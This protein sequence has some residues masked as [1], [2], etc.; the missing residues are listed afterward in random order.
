MGKGHD[1]KPLVTVGIPLYNH[2]NYIR[3]C[4]ESVLDQSYKNIQVIVIDDGSSDSSFAVLQE[5]ATERCDERLEISSRE[6]RG[7]CNTLNEIAVAARGKYISMLGSDDYWMPNKIADQVEY[8][9]CRPEYVLVH[10]GSIKVDSEGR[11]IKKLDYSK[12]ENTGWLFEA[13]IYRRGGINTPS[14]LYRTS[15]YE[16]IGYYDPQ[17]TFEDADFWLRLTKDFDV[18]Y[19]DKDHTFYRWHGQNLSSRKYQLRHYNLQLERIYKKNITEPEHLSYILGRLYRKSV[20]RSIAAL[21][22]QSLKYYMRAYVRLRLD[23]L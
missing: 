5:L 18:G 9:E 7:M 8:L 3:Q 14:H 1:A 10:S 23:E 6:N 22:L 17:F 4:V 15:V 19:I 12:K 21:D 13:M 20:V 16:K 2:E 11:E